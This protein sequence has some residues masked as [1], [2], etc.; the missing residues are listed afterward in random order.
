MH[1]NSSATGYVAGLEG[2]KY[3]SF[4]IETGESKTLELGSGVLFLWDWA[5]QYYG[6][7]DVSYWDGEVRKMFGNITL[8]ASFSKPANS[9]NVKVTCK[10]DNY[11]CH[12]KYLF[13]G[14]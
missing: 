10:L 11:T 12:M 6:L 1:P 9:K 2:I 4:N 13:I 3:G 5:A 7:M 14:D 8:S